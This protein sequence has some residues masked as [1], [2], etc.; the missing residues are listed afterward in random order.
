[1]LET[2]ATP[3]EKALSVAGRAKALRRARNLTQEQLAAKS[4]VSVGSLRRFEQTGSVSFE[5]LIRLMRALEC[6]GE[7]DGL[8]STPPYRSIQEVIDAASKR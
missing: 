5:S 6:E 4:G 3:Q 7:L 1:M 8:F 2:P